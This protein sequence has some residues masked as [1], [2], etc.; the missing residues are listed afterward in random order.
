MSVEAAK[1]WK[2]Y[3]DKL[4]VLRKYIRHFH[5]LFPDPFR[6][7]F[8]RAFDKFGNTFDKMFE[9]VVF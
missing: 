2:L 1:L 3:F 7:F 8:R 9:S 5:R 4:L 6:R